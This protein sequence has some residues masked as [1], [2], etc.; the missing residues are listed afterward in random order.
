MH[1]TGIYAALGTLL[2][3]ALALAQLV[4]WGTFYYAFA[5]LMT[6]MGAELGWSKAE[7][8]GALS[9]GLA[10]T[11]LAAFGAGRWIGGDDRARASAGFISG[12]RVLCADYIGHARIGRGI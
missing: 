9:L 10:V 3:L 12:S 6:P 4:A 2:V 7:M 11:G 5:I 1:I 8:N